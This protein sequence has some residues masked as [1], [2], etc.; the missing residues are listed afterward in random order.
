MTRSTIPYAERARRPVIVEGA[1]DVERPV[2]GFYRMKLRSGG[3]LAGIRIWYG[4]PHDP[5]TGEVMDRSWRWQAEANGEPIDF[6]DAWPKCGG[7][8][9]TEQEYRQYCGKQ[10]W[11]RDHAPKSAFADPKRRYDPLTAPLPF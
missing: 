1:I 2:A 3:V 11:A 7:A 9:I 4:P 8:P 5:E 10:V 6:D